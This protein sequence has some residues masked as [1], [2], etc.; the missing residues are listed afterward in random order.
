M[1][2]LVEREVTITIDG[3]ERDV[4]MR[5]WV[6]VGA[7]GATLDGRPEVFVDGEWTEMDRAE[8][9]RVEDAVCEQAINEESDAYDDR[10]P[11]DFQ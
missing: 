2:R 11:G 5:S 8:I 7:V 1:S 4:P 9:D 10:D 3:D 6:E